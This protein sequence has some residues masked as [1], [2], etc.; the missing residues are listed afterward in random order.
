MVK[1]TITWKGEKFSFEWFD[2]SDF[3]K[4]KDATQSYG[5]LFD[6]EGKIAIID[7]VGRWCLP[8]GTIEKG[9]TF[10]EALIR[11]VLEE[12]DVEIEDITPIGYEKTIS[13]EDAK[14]R[15][16]LRFIAKISKILPQTPD[17]DN[18]KIPK[19]KFIDPSEFLTHCPWGNTGEAMIN[20]AIKLF[21]EKLK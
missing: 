11:E 17:P 14:E 15:S 13:H 7:T 5:V 6:N 12:A 18:G 8:G 1:Q 9:E 21:N 2:N 4:I 10:E 16:Q 3:S 19:R 20:Q